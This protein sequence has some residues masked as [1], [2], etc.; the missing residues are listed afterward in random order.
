MEISKIYVS[1][2]GTE[3]NVEALDYQYLVNAMAKCYRTL[4]ETND[5]DEF[6]KCEKNIDVLESELFKRRKRTLEILRNIRGVK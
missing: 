5:L 2:D 3:K 1:S 6:Y 4:N